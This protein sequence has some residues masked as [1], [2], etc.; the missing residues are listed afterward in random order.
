MRTARLLRNT[1]ANTLPATKR[2]GTPMLF[3]Y[4]NRSPFLNSAINVAHTS[5][6]LYTDTVKL[7][8]RRRS[9]QKGDEAAKP[10]ESCANH[11]VLSAR[12]VES[13]ENRRV[14]R[15]PSSSVCA[16]RRYLR[17]PSSSVC[18]NRRVLREPSSPARTAEACANRRYTLVTIENRVAVVG[19]AAK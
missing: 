4:T 8:M 13:C 1:L 18:E 3:P 9:G 6:T 2:S 17:E 10:V 19:C 16:N 12:T 15:E 11:R 5:V 7:C 14:L